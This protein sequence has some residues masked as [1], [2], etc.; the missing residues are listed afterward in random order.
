MLAQPE[1][2]DA[3]AG[4]GSPLPDHPMIS[5]G[6]AIGITP[7]GVSPLVMRTAS[8]SAA[9]VLLTVV[10]MY[11]LACCVVSIVCVARHSRIIPTRISQWRTKASDHAAGAGRGF[12]EWGEVF[13]KELN[14]KGGRGPPH[15]PPYVGRRTRGERLA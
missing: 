5:L 4:K 8:T 15:P 9:P 1:R 10:A 13:G 6:A 14:L 3:G 2:R 12:A 11:I 7:A